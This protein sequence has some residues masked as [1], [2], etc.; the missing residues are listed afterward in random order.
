LAEFLAAIER[1]RPKLVAEELVSE[2]GIPPLLS[3]AGED[4]RPCSADALAAWARLQEYMRAHYGSPEN[5]GGW[6]V[7]ERLDAGPAE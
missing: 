3:E 1:N 4:C 6:L 7:Y 2:V 5:V